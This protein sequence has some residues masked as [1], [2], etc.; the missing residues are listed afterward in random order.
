MVRLLLLTAAG[1]LVG[2]ALWLN[3]PRPSLTIK[4]NGT[5]EIIEIELRN[6]T[7]HNIPYYDS[8]SLP[9]PGIVFKNI[10][11]FVVVRLYSIDGKLLSNFNPSYDYITV[12]DQE[13]STIRTPVL[14][15]ELKPHQSVTTRVKLTD[16]IGKMPPYNQLNA[17]KELCAQVKVHIFLN[18][19]LLFPVTEESAV[20]CI[21]RPH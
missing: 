5:S 9:Q 6:E 11:T 13:S 16:L 2:F 3:Q 18:P 7:T 20:T 19:Y 8:L 14:M 10:P 15:S 4:L 1:L 21:K 12:R 17:L